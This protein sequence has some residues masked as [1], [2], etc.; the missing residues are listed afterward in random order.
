MQCISME[1]AALLAGIAMHEL[2]GRLRV[3]VL[4]DA[5]QIVRDTIHAGAFVFIC[6]CIIIAYL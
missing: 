3:G 5:L 1:S 6:E 2:E 4:A